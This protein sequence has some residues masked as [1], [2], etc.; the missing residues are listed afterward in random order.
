MSD[1]LQFIRFK[2]MVS[3]SVHLLENSKLV[4]TNNYKLAYFNEF[5]KKADIEK[6]YIEDSVKYKILGVR[7]YG[8]G[9]FLNRE[10]FGSTL[11]MRMYQRVKENHL[12]W[13]KV[14]TKNGG[15]GIITDD[16]SEGVASSNMALAE[17]DTKKINT[18]YLQIFFKSKIFNKYMDN[19]VVGTTNRKYIKFND[20][21]N[22]IK[23]PLPTLK[24]QQEIVKNYQDK[25]NLAKQQEQQAQQKEA[26]I[27]TYLYQELGIELPKEEKQNKDI[28]QFVR[29]KDLDRWDVLDI[30]NRGNL[31]SN[32]FIVNSMSKDNSLFID[33]FRGKSPKYNK[34]SKEIILN[35]K[36]NRWNSIKIKHS[37]S[38]EAN[39]INNIDKN[40]FT[41]KGDILINSTG[42]GTIGRASFVSKDFEGLLYDSHMLLLRVNKDILNSLYITFFINSKFGQEQINN[43]KSAVATK[44]TELGKNNLM[45]IIFI[46]PPLEIQNKI[47]THIQTLKDE[48]QTLKQQAEQN[49]TLALSEFEAEIFNAS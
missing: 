2:D 41:K 45:K 24:K 7:I 25:I 39:W 32:L 10:V 48:I 33:I 16:F 8:L 5:T 1:L 42:E 38:V 18:Q 30:L 47:A 20:L 15:F 9:V 49:K 11:K 14:D 46:L 43:I 23:I 37:K 28:L 12:F 6:V 21:L 31:S 35:Q 26:E 4:F 29:F 36:C 40:L 34:S 17:L 19:L 27:E 44:Q 3:W 22:I 13:C